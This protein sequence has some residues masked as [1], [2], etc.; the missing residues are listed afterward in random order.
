MN[1]IVKMLLCVSTLAVLYS[2]AYAQHSLKV[3][4]EKAATGAA[5]LGFFVYLSYFLWLLE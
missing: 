5:L 2:F 3:K 1:R 4:N